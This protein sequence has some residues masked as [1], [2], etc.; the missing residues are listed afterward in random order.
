MSDPSQ[1]AVE[2]PQ[3]PADVIPEPNQDQR[4]RIWRD[5]RKLVFHEN[6][7]LPDLCIKCNAPAQG[8]RVKRKVEW[9]HPGLGLIAPAGYAVHFPVYGFLAFLLVARIFRKKALV[10]LGYCLFHFVRRRKW[11]IAS[12]V[13]RI[14]SAVLLI[15]AFIPAVARAF[16]EIGNLETMRWGYGDFQGPAL[17]GGLIAFAA[18][19]ICALAADASA[20]VNKIQDHCIWLAGVNEDYLAQ[21]PALETNGRVQLKT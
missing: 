8:V 16:R 4:W 1:P 5:G 3:T 20:R 9:A 15:V 10:S 12:T 21:F 2:G 14:A 19:V 13:G 7:E 6:A 11:V 18:F 17:V